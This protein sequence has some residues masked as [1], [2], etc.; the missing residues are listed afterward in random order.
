M[1]NLYRQ[2]TLISLALNNRRVP[3]TLKLITAM[4]IHTKFMGQF[5]TLQ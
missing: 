5:G 3:I 2:E 4:A 1:N